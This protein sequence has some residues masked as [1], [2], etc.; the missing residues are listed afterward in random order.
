M[1]S[2]A[3]AFILSAAILA[4]GCAFQRT[5][6]T[7]LSQQQ[8]AYFSTLEETLEQKR[9]Y[10]KEGLELQAQ[11]SRIRRQHLADWELS[12]KKAEILLGANRSVKN[13]QQLLAIVL[14][15]TELD[16]NTVRAGL[17]TDEEAQQI[18]KLYDG[19]RSS[20]GALKN[21]NKTIIGYLAS[22]DKEFAIR[23]LDL[24]GVNV[25]ITGV[26]ELQ[27]QLGQIEKRSDEEKKI[28]RERI[29]KSLDR[30]QDILLGAFS[31]DSE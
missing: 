18:L 31:E 13:S 16:E 21:N 4:T 19:I 10:L 3:L 2:R 28:E 11:T 27:E 25:A 22:R 8:E 26:R 15:D 23:S 30:A 9:Q 1:N 6:V 7:A 17:T 12:V 20:I 5:D 14:A 29:E 24:E